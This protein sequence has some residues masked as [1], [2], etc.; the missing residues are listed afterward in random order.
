MVL[1]T[2]S[3][4]PV[5][6]QSSGHPPP[7][8]PSPFAKVLN[9]SICAWQAIAAVATTPV[10]GPSQS[11][12]PEPGSLGE[13]AAL[14]S[15]SV[16]DVATPKQ[17]QGQEV[18]SLPGEGR[19]QQPRAGGSGVAGGAGGAGVDGEG[20]AASGVGGGGH[21]DE[22]ACAADPFRALVRC[23]CGVVTAR[24]KQAGE[25]DGRALKKGVVLHAMEAV[26]AL[27]RAL[28]VRRVVWCGVVT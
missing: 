20:G 24:W 27:T 23:L 19:V 4:F 14:P 22:D 12:A 9:L 26:Y 13:G 15:V 2:W 11:S 10:P 6:S 5:N 25:A 7:P 1:L 28:E 3:F 8:R 17:Q 18:V 21:A 16:A